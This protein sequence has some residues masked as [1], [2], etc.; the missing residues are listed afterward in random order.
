MVIKLTPGR[1]RR[2]LL[3]SLEVMRIALSVLSGIVIGFAFS[4]GNNELKPSK[5]KDQLK[6]DAKKLDLK[7]YLTL[8]GYNWN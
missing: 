5:T 6:Q 2:S 1:D 3:N 7:F 8:N 4:C